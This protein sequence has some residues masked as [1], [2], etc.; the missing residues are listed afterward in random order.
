MKQ[1]GIVVKKAVYIALGV[2]MTGEKEILVFY[3]IG[4]SESVKYWTSIL[5]DIKNRRVKDILIMC[6]DGLKGLK[7]AIGAVYPMTEFQR[8]IVHMIRNTLQYVSYK[9]RK[10]LAQDLKQIYQATTGRSRI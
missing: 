8:C 2:I 7:E 5:N 4:D 10:E 6:S 3:N 9:D 1:D